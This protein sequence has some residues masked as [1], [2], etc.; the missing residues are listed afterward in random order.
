MYWTPIQT[1]KIYVTALLL[2]VIF[3]KGGLLVQPIILGVENWAWDPL[4]WTLWSRWLECATLWIGQS[5]G[6][7]VWNSKIIL[8]FLAIIFLEEIASWWQVVYK[9]YRR[10]FRVILQDI[11]I[12]ISLKWTTNLCLVPAGWFVERLIHRA[13][14]ERGFICSFTS[15]LPAVLIAF[16]ANKSS[17]LPSA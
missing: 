9:C 7:V 11:Y 1:L 6:R 14:S 3:K 16:V 10:L 8:L 15:Q 5:S 4:W 12:K 13:S 2:Y 17:T